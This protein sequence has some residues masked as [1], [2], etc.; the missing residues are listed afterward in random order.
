MH[1][2]TVRPTVRQTVAG[3]PHAA[4]RRPE[5]VITARRPA[6][7]AADLL[8][9]MVSCAAAEWSFCALDGRP[10]LSPRSWMYRLP[11]SYHGRLRLAVMTQCR[12]HTQ[13]AGS[14]G[15]SSREVPEGASARGTK[16]MRLLSSVASS[17]PAG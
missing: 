11:G 16:V 1:K 12:E 2:N 6:D 4:K 3:E 14:A 5:L 15:P 9:S 8:V 10:A 17:R 7:M 13:S